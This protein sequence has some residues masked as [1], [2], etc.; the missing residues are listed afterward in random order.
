MR[1]YG[2]ILAGLC[3][4]AICAALLLG[5]LMY[6]TVNG[7]FAT[8]APTQNEKSAVLGAASGAACSDE[9]G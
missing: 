8:H 5:L 6:P 7:H 1:G 4:L 3:V 2:Q 9:A